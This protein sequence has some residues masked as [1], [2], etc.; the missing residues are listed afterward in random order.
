MFHTPNE[1]WTKKI[2]DYRNKLLQVNIPRN[3]DPSQGKYILSLLDSLYGEIRLIYGDVRKQLDEAESL[4]ERIRRKAESKGSNTEI[5]KANGIDAVE[6]IELGSGNCI[7][8]YNIRTTLNFQKEDLEGLLAIIEKK[9]SMVITMN[10][11]LKIE[12]NIAGH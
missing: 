10:G 3:I 7:N 9:Q 12:S 11:L 1:E 6:K 4:I 8:L 2:A 5:R